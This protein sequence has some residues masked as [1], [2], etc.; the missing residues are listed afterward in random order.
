MWKGCYLFKVHTGKYMT[1]WDFLK[2]SS[3]KKI[4]SLKHQ[5]VNCG[6]PAT[7]SSS[8]A[9]IQVVP[10]LTPPGSGHKKSAWF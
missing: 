3:E 2:Y 7:F 9:A 8:F 4:N 1:K 6:S 5:S 10:V